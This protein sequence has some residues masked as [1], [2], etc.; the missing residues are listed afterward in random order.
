MKEI[1]CQLVGRYMDRKMENLEELNRHGQVPEETRE[2]SMGAFFGNI[3]T[4]QQML[5]NVLVRIPLD[6]RSAFEDVWTEFN[7]IQ[8]DSCEVLERAL[9][10]YFDTLIA[11]LE[12]AERK[13]LSFAKDAMDY[14]QAVEELYLLYCMRDRQT[15]TYMIPQEHPLRRMYKYLDADIDVLL[16]E[17][18]PQKNFLENEKPGMT[19]DQI[20]YDIL[21]SIFQA[22]KK[23]RRQFK[24][25]CRNQ[26][27]ET[28]RDEGENQAWVRAYPFR[29]KKGNTEIPYIRIW[30]KL[31]SYESHQPSA[32]INI[33]V[34]GQL[35]DSEKQNQQQLLEKLLK[36]EGSISWSAFESC[37]SVGEYYFCDTNGNQVYDISNLTDLEELARRYQI[38]LFLDVNCL[39]RQRQQEKNAAERN[40]GIHC[41]WYLDR[42]AEQREFKDKAAYF[43]SI[44]DHIGLWLNSLKENKSST[45]EFNEKIYRNLTAVS[46]QNTDIYL[47]VRYGNRIASH[48]LEYSGTCNDEYYDGRQ[49][50]VCKLARTDVGAFNSAYQ[51]FLVQRIDPQNC[52]VL[53]RMWKLLKSISNAYCNDA[54]DKLSAEMKMDLSDLVI[55][56]NDSYLI[57]KYNINV[58]ENK[59]DLCYDVSIQ[60]NSNAEL[61]SFIESL[62]KIVLNYA[63]FN[64]NLYCIK[65]YF[66]ELLIHSVISNA[67]D[68]GDLVFAH[69]LSLSWMRV[70]SVT[71]ESLQVDVVE[72][73]FEKEKNK[74]KVRKTAYAIIERL[75]NLRMRDIPDMQ[76][77]FLGTFRGTVCP[78]VSE[79]NILET[80]HLITDCCEYF[81]HTDSSL[82]VN[83]RL[84]D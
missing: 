2:A 25:Y 68:I 15:N 75:E 46:R 20:A 58:N 26:V 12:T 81:R 66:K 65:R 6:E 17:K 45:F 39:Y 47:Y 29:Q 22:K 42:S 9:R 73:D 36:K 5:E 19:N 74:F 30:E 67:N 80:F 43:Q 52:Y 33:A 54:L 51:N 35:T 11:Y 28:A 44:Y 48:N 70:S 55:A 83:S 13:M 32:S 16:E 40:E 1:I 60:R 18:K 50:T 71:K 23:N 56:L 62:S 63:F 64:D 82:F 57:L 3:E 8:N 27:Y 61:L 78:E 69:I 14:C 77:Y 4:G 72:S 79:D 24:L 31:S 53:I 84:I 37:P 21:E 7:H 59:I 34:F 38:I 49:L 76:G 10:H 41:R